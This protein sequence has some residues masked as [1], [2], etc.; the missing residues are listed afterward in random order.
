MAA[1]LSTE[2]T[3]RFRSCLF[4]LSA[5]W[6]QGPEV[7]NQVLDL[8][9]QH[10]W[11]EDEPPDLFPVLVG[12]ARS[13]RAAVDRLVEIDQK[14]YD[15]NEQM[16]TLRRFR[17]NAVKQLGRQMVALRGAV[18]G[19]FTEPELEGL[20]L[21]D[22]NAREPLALQRQAELICRKVERE[23]LERTLGEPV[24]VAG[25]DPRPRAAEMKSV[26]TELGS[27]LGQMNSAQRRIDEVLAAKTKAMSDYDRVFLRVARQFEDQCRFA[28][29][30]ELAAKVRPSTTRPGRTEL[31][32]DGESSDAEDATSDAP[33]AEGE[34]SPEGTDAEA[35]IA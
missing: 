29:K 31:D 18:N 21:Q 12:F 33:A 4:V 22:P 3:S 9:R 11:E 19:Q 5:L 34:T 32:P 2:V 16:S 1:K 14:L 13:L 23:D 25:F 24:F 30:D 35:V 7:A 8:V 6:Q 17:D 10:L 26:V 20:G 15:E 28:G 27:T